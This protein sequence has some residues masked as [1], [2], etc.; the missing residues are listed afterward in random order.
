MAPP[1]EIVIIIYHNCH[2]TDD[3]VHG[4]V[5]TCAN[6]I[7]IYISRSITFTQFIQKINNRLLTRATEKVVQLLFRVPISFHYDQT[8]YISIVIS[9]PY[10]ISLGSNT[11]YFSTT[12]RQ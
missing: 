4:L 10:F 12:T 5:Y 6:P 1:K 11:L 3:P 7:F 2:I 8:H 9:C